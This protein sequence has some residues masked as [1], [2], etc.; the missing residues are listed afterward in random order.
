[1]KDEGSESVF[2]IFIFSNEGSESVSAISI[3]NVGEGV[4]END[5]LALSGTGFASTF[6]S[7]G[8]YR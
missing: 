1:M 7:I 2:T 5:G 4:M 6:V 3:F 8:S